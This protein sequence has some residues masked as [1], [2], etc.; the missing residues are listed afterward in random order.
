MSL[1][2]R[3]V[4]LVAGK[5]GVGRTTVA[6]TLGLAAGELGLRAAVVELYGSGSVP[7]RFGLA[8]R[9]FT[10]RAIAPNVDTFSLTPYECLDDFGRK[11]LRVN[12]LVRMLFHNRVFRA[13]IDAVPGMHDLFQLGKIN[14]LITTPSADDPPYDLL[15]LDA[16]ATG[17]GLTLLA[18]ADS[19]RE[20]VGGGLVADE[21]EL[22]QALLHD[23][24]RT[25]IVLV[26]LP[27]ELPVNESLELLEQLGVNERLLA[28]GIVNQVRDLRLP[29]QGWTEMAPVLE[30]REGASL[31]QLGRA[32][33]LT[34]E[35]Q[36]RAIDRFREALAT[37]D[38][39]TF[40]LPRIEPHELRTSDQPTLAEALR[41]QL[42]APEAS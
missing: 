30:A 11:K 36:I 32:A 25:G 41:A 29:E 13:F 5:G 31:V 37:R 23:P 8:D 15:I 39:P 17:H 7:P 9:S 42:R 12:A 16:P 28:A 40:T 27:D 20:M 21:A 2:N 18:A 4:L 6:I 26:T 19:M 3:K 33:I 24:E 1:F 22:I 10:P 38:V 35:R 34:K 14:H